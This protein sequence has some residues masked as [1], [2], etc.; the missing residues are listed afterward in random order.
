M[1]KIE[2]LYT[3]EASATGGRNGNV[4]S[5][6]GILD[7]EVRMPKELRGEAENGRKA[8]KQYISSIYK[9]YA[10]VRYGRCTEKGYVTQRQRYS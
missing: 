7:L 2:K 8:Y 5:S 9:Y 10:Y 6:D 1:D 4:K 3:A